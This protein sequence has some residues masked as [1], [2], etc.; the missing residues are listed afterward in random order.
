M[1]RDVIHLLDIAHACRTI[2]YLVNGMDKA[3][4]MSDKRTQL[5]IL[6]QLTIIGEIVKRLSLTFR[7]DYS[8]KPWKQIAG[9]RDVLV[10]SYNQIDLDLTRG[11][12][13]GSIPDLLAFLHPLLPEEKPEDSEDVD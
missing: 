13:Q 6:Y 7:Q 10:Y 4:F 3:S 12:I 2:V 8:Q 9:M 1:N 5:A 11:V